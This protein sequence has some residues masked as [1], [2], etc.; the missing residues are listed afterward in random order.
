M[1]R[2][3]SL[4]DLFG[5]ILDGR[6]LMAAPPPRGRIGEER[7]DPPLVGCSAATV[8]L[9]RDVAVLAASEIPV[10][11]EGRERNREGDRRANLHRLSDRRGSRS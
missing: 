6:G 1:V 8:S 7:F 9:R 11:I 10:L 3:V 2:A 5:S 4:L